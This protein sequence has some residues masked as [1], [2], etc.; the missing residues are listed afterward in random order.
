MALSLEKMGGEHASQRWQS[1][2]HQKPVI[3]ALMVSG[4][5]TPLLQ[6]YVGGGRRR[7]LTAR[8][9]LLDRV[10]RGRKMR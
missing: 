3:Q 6:A 7:R 2:R 8:C 5:G 1:W 4:V 9:C 10:K